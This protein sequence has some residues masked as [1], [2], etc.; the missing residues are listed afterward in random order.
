[1]ASDM[2]KRFFDLVCSLLGLLVLSPVYALV[3][4]LVK[5]SGPG[6]VLFRQ[7]RVGRDFQPFQIRKFRTMTK[8]AAS[9]P[10][11]TIRGDRRVTCIGQFLRKTKLDELPQLINVVKGDMSLVGPRPEVPQYVER[12]R[13]DY[14]EI[15]KVRPG[16]TDEASILFRHEDAVLASAP[17]PQ[18]FYVE[19]ILPRKIALAKTYV[20]NRSLT[21]DLLLIL[22]T[23]LH[24]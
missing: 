9:D 13:D 7:V 14:E 11:I 19:Q 15:L 18:K 20:R 12:F 2:A 5:I 10:P 24:L 21:R 1:M 8:D 3:T 16:I 4:L 22:R 6:P 17:D 23:I